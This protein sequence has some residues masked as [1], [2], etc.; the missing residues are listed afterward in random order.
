[1]DACINLGHWLSHFKWSSTVIISKPNKQVYDNSK[2][3][4]PIVLLN[5][6]GLQFHA[7]KNDFIHSSQL[8]SLKF[9]LT[10]DAGVMLTHIIYSEW[11]KNRTIS[12]LTFDIVQ[13]FPFLN[14]YLLILSLEKADFDFRVMLFFADF[15][16]QR[17]TNYQW[18]KFFSLIYEVNVEVG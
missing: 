12:I 1:M 4:W 10:L 8:G 14:Y 17:K 9:K 3:F 6:L 15:L 7:I 2:S 16:V 11:V 5:T 18:N 13:F